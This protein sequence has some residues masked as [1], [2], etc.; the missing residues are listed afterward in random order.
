[1]GSMSAP[2]AA[3][4]PRLGEVFFD[5]R[6]SSRSMRLS[7][8]SDTGVAVFSIW[9]GGTCTGTFRLP[10]ED[11]SR[12]IEALQRGPRGA[13]LPGA[14]SV[15]GTGASGTGAGGAGRRSFPDGAPVPPYREYATGQHIAP[16]TGE[17]RRPDLGDR[18]APAPAASYPEPAFRDDPLGSGSYRPPAARPSYSPVPAVPA[19]APSY[20]ERED[21][22]TSP[23]YRDQARSV[24]AYRGDRRWGDDPLGS[25]SYRPP[26]YAPPPPSSHGEVPGYRDRA[27]RPYG[28]DPL[29]AGAYRQ[30]SFQLPDHG[31]EDPGYPPAHRDGDSAGYPDREPVSYPGDEPG[32]YRGGEPGGYRYPDDPFRSNYPQESPGGSR[33]YAPPQHEPHRH[34]GRPSPA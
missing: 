9:Q 33:P 22:L 31:P 34:R 24:A 17:F 4:L 27:N 20:R 2:D 16:V 23:S 15:P 14:D 6:G 32:G 3:P 11:M 13:T 28:D 12:M 1:M 5:V 26:G 30:P 10:I 25:G 21:P 18:D 19:P 8:Y 7:W 29:G